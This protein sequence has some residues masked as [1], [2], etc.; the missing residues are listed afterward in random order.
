MHRVKG[1]WCGNQGLGFRVAENDGLPL[2]IPGVYEDYEELFRPALAL[3]RPIL[4]NSDS[5][6]GL[7]EQ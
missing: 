1:L 5:L 4:R 2:G 6:S 3:L 7:G